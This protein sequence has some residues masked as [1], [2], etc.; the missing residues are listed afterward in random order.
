[1]QKRTSRGV[2]SCTPSLVAQIDRMYGC[3][4]NGTQQ[5][6]VVLFPQSTFAWKFRHS[7]RKHVKKWLRWKEFH[8]RKCSWN[9]L[10]NCSSIVPEFQ[11]I[12]FPVGYPRFLLSVERP[13]FI[14]IKIL[15]IVPR[16]SITG[17]IWEHFSLVF[18]DWAIPA[19]FPQKADVFDKRKIVGVVADQNLSRLQIG[20]WRLVNIFNARTAQPGR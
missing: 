18:I 17:H 8:F 11:N 2:P 19:K 5:R 15:L 12:V 1:M 14:S 3:I 20:L 4:D 16:K 7:K 6:A 10:R 13:T 9:S